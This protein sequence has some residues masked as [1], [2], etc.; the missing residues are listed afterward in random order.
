MENFIDSLLVDITPQSIFGV[1][2]GLLGGIAATDRNRY[3]KTLTIIAIIFSGLAGGALAAYLV[4]YQKITN[5]FS[6]AFFCGLGGMP[7]GGLMDAINLI[8]PNFTKKLVNK[9]SD[10]TIEKVDIL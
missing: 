6:I 7:I 10:K 4:N 3:G 1:L 9:L 8:S 2:G 5:I